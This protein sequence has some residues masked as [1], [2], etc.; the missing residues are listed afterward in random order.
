MGSI[1]LRLNALWSSAREIVSSLS[2]YFVAISI[3]FD[4][5]AVVID[6][7]RGMILWPPQ[8]ESFSWF[9]KHIILFIISY[10]EASIFSWRPKNLRVVKVDVILKPNVD[11]KFA[12]PTAFVQNEMEQKIK[13]QTMLFQ[14]GIPVFCS[15]SIGVAQSI[16]YPQS[17]ALYS[18]ADLE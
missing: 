6:S 11:C 9:L 4:V 10:P 16:N 12:P 3:V 14:G 2:H 5:T 7:P 15:P 17:T 13:R 18:I 1:G 8:H